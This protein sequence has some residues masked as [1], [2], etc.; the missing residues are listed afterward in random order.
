MGGRGSSFSMPAG[1]KWSASPGE[2][3]PETLKEAIGKKGAPKS[4]GDAVTSTNPHFSRDYRE[5]S[6][7]CQRCV[8]AYELRRRGYNVEALPTYKGS[9]LNQ[10]V[11]HDAAKGVY[12]ARWRGAFKG[13]K[14][15]NVG[16]PGNTP[17]A[18]RA[19]MQNIA[20]KMHSYGVGSRAVIQVFYR[21]G[22]GHVFN[23]ENQGGRIVYVEA[24]SGRIRDAAATMRSVKTG[25]VN[26]VRV[27][28]L[29]ISNRAQKFVRQSKK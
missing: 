24:Q 5:F 8:V 15:E 20:N 29:K 14:T 23:V 17:K 3:E 13:A 2:K 11:H 16:V 22:G 4:L 12:A 26:I 19:V 10:V 28:N 25:A 27:D 21:G 6:E 18:E 9:T 1:G 7:N